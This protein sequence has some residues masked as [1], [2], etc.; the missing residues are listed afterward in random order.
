MPQAGEAA[1]D[2]ARTAVEVGFVLASLRV[3]DDDLADGPALTAPQAYGPPLPVD[4]GPEDG[5]DEVAAAALAVDQAP[6]PLAAEGAKQS[7]V[8]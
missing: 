8:P 2:L 6:G 4:V 7:R 3:V 1:R 5:N